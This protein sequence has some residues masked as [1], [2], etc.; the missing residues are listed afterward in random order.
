MK[1]DRIKLI[2]HFIN[3]CSMAIEE[4]NKVADMNCE[5]YDALSIHN[6]RFVFTKKDG[7]LREAYGTMKH[8]VIPQILGTGRPLNF[9]LQLYFDLDKMSW[10]SF[11]KANLVSYEICE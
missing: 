5:L 6:V 11:K 8:D 4:A 10:R 3:Q 1:S 9:D 2:E 7:T